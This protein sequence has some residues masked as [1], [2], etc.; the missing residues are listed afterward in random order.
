MP[1]NELGRPSTAHIA[2]FGLRLQEELKK[3]LEE[4][5]RAAGRSLNAEITSRLAH[6]FASPLE[7]ERLAE[8]IAQ[9]ERLAE[10]R[11]KT[12]EALSSTMYAFAG[13]V[14]VLLERLP[15]KERDTPEVEVWRAMCDSVLHGDAKSLAEALTPALAQSREPGLGE[16]FLIPAFVRKSAN[17]AAKK[18]SR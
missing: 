7:P 2:P 5:A 6:S 11:G 8:H 14:R 18:K 15:P 1:K 13:I 10:E 3:Q 9:L 17:P 12:A 16:E 4:S